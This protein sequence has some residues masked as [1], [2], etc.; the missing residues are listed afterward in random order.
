[1]GRLKA[2]Y[3]RNPALIRLVVTAYIRGA[4][5]ERVAEQL[6]RS[7]LGSPPDEAVARDPEFV[8]DYFRSIGPFHTG[9]VGGYV[10]ELTAMTRAVDPKPLLGRSNWR[11][12]LG[13]S[14]FMHDPDTVET[15]WKRVLPDTP[16]R[17]VAE[18]GRFLAMSHPEHVVDALV[19]DPR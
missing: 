15:Y 3:L 5:I 14:D 4:D 10:D 12:L 18:A 7:V 17:R 9:R 1:M 19:Q 2:I 16:F 6:R 11:I 8:R 13:A